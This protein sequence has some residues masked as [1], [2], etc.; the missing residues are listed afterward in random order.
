MID[1]PRAALAALSLACI[2]ALPSTD[3]RAQ[4]STAPGRQPPRTLP[5]VTARPPARPPAARP[6]A[7]Q[8][9]R[10]PATPVA[11]RPAVRPA[12]APATAPAAGAMSNGETWNQITV[13]AINGGAMKFPVGRGHVGPSVLRVQVLLDRAYFSPAMIDGRWGKNSQNAVYWLQS[14]EG[15]PATGT[16]DSATYARLEQLAGAPAELVR[17]HVLSA[18]DVRGPFVAIPENIY[19]HARLSCSCYETLSEKL[20]ELFHTRGDLLQKLNPGV[21][22]NAVKA[23]DTLSVLNVRDMGAPPAGVVTELIVSGTDNYVQALD[24]SG[25]ILYHFAATL[26]SSFDPSP[27]GDF[28]VLSVHPN[29]WWRYQPK[30]LAHVP[31]W[32]PEALIPPGPNNS[33]GRV[34]MTLSAPHYGIHGTKSPETIGY[35]QSAGCVRLTNWDVMFLSKR[36]NPGTPVNFRGTRP[37]ERQPAPAARESAPRLPGVR[38]DSVRRDSVAAPRDTGAARAPAPRDT[39]AARAPAPVR[40]DTAA[41]DTAPR[42]APARDTT[43]AAAPRPSTP[44]PAPAAPRPAPTRP[45]SAAAARPR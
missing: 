12:A 44:A 40:R 29:P 28:R 6:T 26:G 2:L 33:V 41:R 21:D 15:L 39:A 10:P 42:P 4:A 1:R 24:S 30:I 43:P 22:L 36:L 38:V 34:W 27:Q 11:N 8:P 19:E 3:A 13:D 32:K 5:A 9:A 17:R 18:E 35:A 14:R 16:V 23:G 25:R 31:D 37:G 7:A 20:T 45:D